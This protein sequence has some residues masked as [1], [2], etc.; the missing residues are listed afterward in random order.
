METMRAT[1]WTALL[2]ALATGWVLFDPA[3]A[4][5]G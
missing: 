2:L 4:A 5:A 3:L 1:Y